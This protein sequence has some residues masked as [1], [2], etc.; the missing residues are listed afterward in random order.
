I[1]T[2]YVVLRDGQER[3]R[4]DE[5]AF[6][7]VGG[8][9]P[10]QEFIYQLRACNKA[11]CTESTKVVAVTAQGVPEDVKPP[12]VTA[13]SSSSLRVNW[14]VPSHPNGVIQKYHLNQSGVG[15]IFTHTGGPNIYTV[16]GKT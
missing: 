2:H 14:S 6:T 3:Y 11:G 1:I 4:G 12:V 16:K 9:R 5:N 10:F 7:D 8:I 15:T 13:V